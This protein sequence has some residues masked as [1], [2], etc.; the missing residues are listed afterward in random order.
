M[1]RNIIRGND[2]R[3]VILEGVNILADTIK[4]TLGPK[5]RN[6]AIASE[7]K[8]PY[9][10]NDGATIARELSLL[11]PALNVGV[12]M[13]KEVALRTNDL[14]GD[15]TTTATIL[16]QAI[17]SRT[18]QAINNNGINPMILKRQL[19]SLSTLVISQL[20]EMSR[21]ILSSKDIFNLAHISC[22][23]AY[24]ASLIQKA[25]ESITKNANISLEFGNATELIVRE[26]YQLEAGVA[27]RY[28][29]EENSSLL[30]MNDAYVIMSDIP[31][32]DY[33][34]IERIV[35]EV[36]ERGLS[37]ILLVSEIAESVLQTL[38]LK[39][40]NEGLNLAVIQAEMLFAT[41]KNLFVDL[42]K[43][44][45]IPFYDR[46]STNSL[47]TIQ[48]TNLKPIIEV[49][50][51]KKE[52]LFLQKGNESELYISQ[53]KKELEIVETEFAKEQLEYRL[54][55]LNG[56]QA[57]ITVGGVTSLEQKERKMKL[58]D[59]ILSVKA[60]LSTGILPGEEV[61]YLKARTILESYLTKENYELAASI[62]YSALE[63]PFE[64][65]LANAG[66]ENVYS[67]N[68]TNMEVGQGIHLDSEAYVD[69]FEVGIID[70][71]MSHISALEAAISV[72][73]LL[74][75]T[76]CILVDE[77]DDTKKKK[78]EYTN[79]LDAS[80]NGLL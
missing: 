38:I 79:L 13:V 26:G 51:G 80:S 69:L 3:N 27:S 56:V 14:A 28:F 16:A 72:S 24:C 62:L 47:E 44:L 6:I 74:F 55:K 60:A 25:Y 64:Q 46:E 40:L 70:S 42:S 31:I 33:S 43:Y 65:L 73:N 32:M 75:T 45:N 8:A 30:K 29:L 50:I 18:V 9:M 41:N 7:F 57:I 68:L 4:V 34:Q 78:E 76:E 17:L 5:G 53:L 20:K 22:G 59:A 19:E 2:A 58:E 61:S 52:T 1:Q 21:P 39:R 63:Q 54:E 36:E 35:D 10:T 49:E 66:I 15:G 77:T 23:D 37:L 12:E 11:D 71:T 48:I 67:N